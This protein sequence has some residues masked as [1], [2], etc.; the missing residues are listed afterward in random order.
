VSGARRFAH[1]LSAKLTLAVL[2]VDDVRAAVRQR[3]IVVTCTPSREPIV[4]GDFVAPG[5][6][7]GAVGA[8]ALK[9]RS[10]RPTYRCRRGGV[11]AR[12][13][14]RARPYGRIRLVIA[15]APH[16]RSPLDRQASQVSKQPGVEERRRQV[17]DEVVT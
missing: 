2:A 3:A 7:L 12:G 16:A 17:P 6:F 5:A 8:D 14:D 13:G 11:R 10:S 1:E 9:S 15:P 4:F